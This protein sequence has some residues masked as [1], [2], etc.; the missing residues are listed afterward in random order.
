MS[1]AIILILKHPV[2]LF[3]DSLLQGLIGTFCFLVCLILFFL[4]SLMSLWNY[5][6]LGMLILLTLKVIECLPTIMKD[7]LFNFGE[8]PLLGT[9]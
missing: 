8:R 5:L 1:L 4:F 7:L 9:V 6:I 2:K 3:A